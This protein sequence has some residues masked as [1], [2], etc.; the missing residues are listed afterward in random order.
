[1]A[2]YFRGLLAGSEEGIA[3][4]I[5]A[6]RPKRLVDAGP[7]TRAEPRSGQRATHSLTEAAIDLV[8]VIAEL[9][10]WGV[11][12]RTTTSRLRVRAELFTD[13][14]PELWAEFMDELREL[15]P[16]RPHNDRRDPPVV[17]RMRAADGPPP[18]S[19]TMPDEEAELLA[20]AA[21]GPTGPRR[22]RR[23]R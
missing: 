20:P 15:H 18:I 16:G 23:S 13:G 1:M 19:A 10:A 7:L 11:R 2:G 6:P 3:S 8:P 4:S 12:H 22:G 17:E 9:G 21:R 5:L 14:G